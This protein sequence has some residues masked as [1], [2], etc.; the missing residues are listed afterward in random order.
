MSGAESFTEETDCSS[1]QQRQDLQET[2]TTY[3]R[4]TKGTLALTFWS[5]VSL[6]SVIFAPN[7]VNV[8]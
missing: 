8:S 4:G 2:I 5:T 6:T 3:I 7:F 1:E